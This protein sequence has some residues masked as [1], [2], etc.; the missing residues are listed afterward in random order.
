MLL[1]L[2]PKVTTLEQALQAMTDCSQR[3]GLAA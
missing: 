1:S 3:L 2:S